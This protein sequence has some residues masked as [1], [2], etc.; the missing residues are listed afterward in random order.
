MA[1]RT[2]N[3]ASGSLGLDYR[4]AATTP[5]KFGH[6]RRLRAD[7]IKVQYDQAVVAAVDTPG[8]QQSVAHVRQVPA[9]A[10]CEMKAA[11]EAQRVQTPRR[12]GRRRFHPVAVRAEDGAAFELAVKRFDR[13]PRDDH[14]AD[15]SPLL[16]QVV[17]FQNGGIRLAANRAAPGP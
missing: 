5:G 15:V 11:I 2:P 12:S 8:R 7:M 16:L 3:L 10:G 1:V 4:E 13:G 14:V 6:I 17:E 9:L